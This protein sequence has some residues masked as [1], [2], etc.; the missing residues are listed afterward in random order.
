MP[1]PSSIV[2]LLKLQRAQLQGLCEIRGARKMAPIYEAARA[3]LEKRLAWMKREGLDRTFTAQHAR[4]ALAQVK[5]AILFFQKNLAGHLTKNARTAAV[6]SHR[7]VV[8]AVKTLERTFSGHTPVLQLEQAAVFRKVYQGVEPSLLDRY[9]RSSALYGPPVVAK[10]R[11]Q[12]STSIL[13]AETVDQATERIMGTFGGERWRAER[14]ARTEMSYGYHLVKQRAMEQ[15]RDDVPDMQKRLVAT[16]DSRTGEDS[17][18]LDGQTVDVAK[19]F[20]WNE[21]VKGGGT[22]VVR[23]MHPPNRPHDREVVIPWRPGWADSKMPEAG[24]V[25]PSTAGVPAE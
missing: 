24:P 14:I 10:I 6:L 21:P 1:A 11:D 19:P 2:Q 13:A 8:G 4:I 22:K 7:H 5:D 17:E 23:Y 16:H 12:L 15:L 18:E 20:I 9:K 25:E 3:D